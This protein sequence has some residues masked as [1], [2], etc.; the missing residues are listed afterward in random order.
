MPECNRPEVLYWTRC[1]GKALTQGVVP[2]GGWYFPE[3][4]ELNP[5][6]IGFY[7]KV[8][9]AAAQE[10][11]PYLMFGAMLRPPTIDVPRITAS[12]CKFILDENSHYIAPQQRHEVE[13]WAVQHSAWRGRDG[14]IGYLFVN[15][16]EEPVGFD[17]DLS[18]YGREAETFDVERVTDGVRQAWLRAVPL[19]RRER[20][21]MEPLSVML[22]EV[23]ECLGV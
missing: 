2:T 5:T 18:A 4:A 21:E 1:L 22:V 13:D 8:V 19:P 7:R 14:T 12:Y 11:W 20:I 10:C 9:R 17:V 23:K 15:V 6:T 3:P 16:S